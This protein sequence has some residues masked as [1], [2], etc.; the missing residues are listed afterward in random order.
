[1][2]SGGR[3]YASRRNLNDGYLR[4]HRRELVPDFDGVD[5]PHL[6]HDIENAVLGKLFEVITLCAAFQDDA[7]V[8]DFNM[9][10][11]NAAMG[12]LLHEFFEFGKK[13]GFVQSH[14]VRS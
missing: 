4:I 5:Q 3:V 11:P 6:G 8:V 2:Q 13:V 12:A 10:I 14:R 1:L 7:V 9:K